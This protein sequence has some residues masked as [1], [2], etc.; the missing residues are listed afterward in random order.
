MKVTPTS[1]VRDIGEMELLPPGYY[2][3]HQTT[4]RY[5]PGITN[6]VDTVSQTPEPEL[7]TR[8]IITGW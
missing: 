4:A 6:D 5:C 1:S 3:Y 2:A 8:I 7:F